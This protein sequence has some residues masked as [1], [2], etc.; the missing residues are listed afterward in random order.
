MIENWELAHFPFEKDAWRYKVR[1]RGSEQDVQE[2]VQRLGSSC[3]RPFVTLSQDYNWAFYIYGLDGNK[4]EKVVAVLK[5]VCPRGSVAGASSW[6]RP[7]S[8]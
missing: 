5:Q 7:P 2:L 6:R 1:I 4:G 3:G 8:P